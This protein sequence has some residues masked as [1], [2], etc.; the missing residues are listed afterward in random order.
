MSTW[1]AQISPDFRSRD[2]RRDAGNA[3]LMHKRVMSLVPDGLGDQA[4]LKAGLLYRIDNTP[5]GP[6]ILVQAQLKPDPARLPGGYGAVQLRELDPL[7]KWLQPGT[8]VRYRLAGS[9]C[10][11]QNRKE[12]VALRG[13]DA[14]NWW[15]SRAPA[16]GLAL[17]SL[18]SKA[19]GD[20]VGHESGDGGSKGNRIVHPLT[21]FD[22]VAA[23]TDPAALTNAIVTGVGRGKSYGCGLLSIAPLGAAA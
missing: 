3:V 23:V 20:A 21:M 7:L 17:Q 18:V 1:L 19:P 8:L 5:G 14:E 2:A 11:R 6:R 16:A 10:K 12:V 22:G 9:T 4:R 15:V 13:A